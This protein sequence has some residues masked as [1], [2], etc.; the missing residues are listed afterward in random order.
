M[1]S[2]QE[3]EILQVVKITDKATLPSKAY[4]NSAGHDLYS[5]YDYKI[6]AQGKK[7]IMTDIRVKVPEG[8][9]GRI[10]PR[11]GPAM[12]NHISIGA[13]VVDEDYTGAGV[14]VEDYT[15]NLSI[16]VFHLSNSE[17]DIKAGDSVA[18]LIC[19]KIALP[20]LIEVTSLTQ[21]ER[22]EKGFGSSE[23]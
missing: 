18:Q 23:E 22:G 17:F 2:V 7:K 12:Q 6:P 9:Y 20:T 11:S 16:L 21:T 4:R 14:V 3:L 13:G 10:A 19:E 8:T 5:A 15:G 1:D